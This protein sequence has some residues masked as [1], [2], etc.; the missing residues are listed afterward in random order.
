MSM[1]VRF[2]LPAMAIVP[3]ATTATTTQANGIGV[4]SDS[5]G[6][7]S[8]W[9]PDTGQWKGA[10]GSCEEWRLTMP[11]CYVNV[12]YS[13]RGKEFVNPSKDYPGR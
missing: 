2:I 7:C 4:G 9:T 1:S 3:L 6:I 11:R 5:K 12:Y 13:G 8:G 10:G